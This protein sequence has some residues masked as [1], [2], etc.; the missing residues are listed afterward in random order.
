MYVRYVS[1]IPKQLLVSVD[2]QGCWFM[3]SHATCRF[4]ESKKKGKYQ[5]SKKNQAPLLTQDTNGKLTTSQLDIT[6][7]SQEV[8]TYPAADH[9]ASINRR[10]KNI[11]KHDKNNKLE[12]GDIAVIQI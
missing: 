1:K 4:H 3:Y 5:E 6:N 10:A 11:T 9:T 2:E 7:E 12:F 8:T